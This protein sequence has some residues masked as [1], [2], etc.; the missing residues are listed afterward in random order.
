MPRSHG[1]E[2]EKAQEIR[3]H[4][5]RR[6]RAARMKRGL[7]GVELAR[8]IG[9]APATISGWERGRY[10]PSL[11]NLRRLVQATGEPSSYFNPERLGKRATIEWLS[12]DL[13]SK[14]GQA[15]L[16]KLLQMPQESPQTRDRLDPRA[17][18]RG[19]RRTPQPE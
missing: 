1:R 16:K 17:P 3:E 9:V 4:L 19:A 14:L 15:R 8:Q 7:K 13:G 18:G 5:G 10:E 2:D 6:I 11:E 12:R